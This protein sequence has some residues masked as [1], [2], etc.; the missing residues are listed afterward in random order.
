MKA[1]IRKDA[2]GLYTFVGG[3][4]VRPVGNKTRFTDGERVDVRHAYHVAEIGKDVTCRKGEYLEEWVSY[5]ITK[6]EYLQGND[7]P[8]EA[9]RITESEE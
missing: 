9:K 7:N 5:S 3:W 6:D 2:I 4:V 1:T 8:I